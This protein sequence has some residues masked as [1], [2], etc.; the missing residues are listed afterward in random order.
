[1][2]RIVYVFLTIVVIV[3][4]GTI[5]VRAGE[6]IGVTKDS[7]KIGL[8]GDLTG[9]IAEGWIQ[10]AHGAKSYFKMVNDEGGIHGRKID[11]ILEDDRYSIPLALSCFKKLVYKD[12]IFV[13]QAASGVGHTAALVPLV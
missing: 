5:P 4:L 12:K 13:L 3:L 1:M 9:P 11:Y 6:D 10:I 7:V 8:M 2:K